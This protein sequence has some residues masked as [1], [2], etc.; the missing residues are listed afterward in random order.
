MGEPDYEP[1]CGYPV[2]MFSMMELQSVSGE[3]DIIAL[4]DEK[5]QLKTA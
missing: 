2:P 5:V 3:T 4:V 1:D